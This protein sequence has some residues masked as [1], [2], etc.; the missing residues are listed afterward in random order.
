MNGLKAFGVA[1]AVI[2]GFFLLISLIWG[3][4]FGGSWLIA[5]PQGKLEARQQILSG[6]FRITAYDHFFNQ[7]VS[8]QNL[9]ASLDAQRENLAALP[10]GSDDVTRI[11]ANISGIQAA[12]FGAI[13]QYNA[14]AEK[15]YTEGQFRSMKLPSYIAPTA[16]RGEKTT[17]AA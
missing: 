6:D 14:D 16:Y 3:L 11:L 2:V 10:K 17:C 12:R 15:N 4:A 9:E 13:N 5:G 1:V 8:I 7:C